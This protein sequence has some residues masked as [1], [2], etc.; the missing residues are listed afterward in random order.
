MMI[1]YFSAFCTM[2]S[3]CALLAQAPTV[4]NV[5]F[6]QR[7]DGSFIVDVYYDVSD[8][9]DDSVDVILE[10]SD[11]F[12]KN[13]F[14]PC[15]SIT[16]DV[17]RGIPT[18][19]SKHIIWDF[20]TDNPNV[21]GD[22]FRLRVTA[23]DE[24]CGSVIKEDLTLTEDLIATSIGEPA[25]AIT[26]GAPNITLDLGGHTIRCDVN[27]QI[28][29]GVGNMPYDGITIKNGTIEGCL[30]GVGIGNSKDVTIE[31]LTIRNLDIWDA[32]TN[33]FGITLS[34]CENV[35]VKNCSIVLPPAVH[36]SGIENYH[37]YAI[38]DNVTFIGGAAGVNLCPELDP[39]DN[40]IIKNSTFTGATM[41]AILDL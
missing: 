37:S 40:G 41:A 11:N 15:W 25:S 22:G 30:I 9:D 27:Q 2:I 28:F 29:S 24:L 35:S 26:I 20:F 33:V 34:L 14:L 4:E 36:K 8:P 38:V 12:G 10:A 7:T 17:G 21:S 31:N 32:A 39:G 1:K 6:T 16:G 18:G 19:T 5:R 23:F 3:G 13:Y